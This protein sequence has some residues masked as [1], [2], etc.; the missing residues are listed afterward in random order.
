MPPTDE[1][2]ALAHRLIEG[3][4]KTFANAEALFV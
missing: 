3:A 1:A 4:E 2:A